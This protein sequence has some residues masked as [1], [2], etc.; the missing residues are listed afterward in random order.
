MKTNIEARVDAIN[1]MRKYINKTVPQLVEILEAGFTRKNDGSLFKKDMERL[2][3]VYHNEPK[4]MRAW[5]DTGDYSI[6]M[7]FD[8]N[9]MNQ[10]GGSGCFYIKE[11]VYLWNIQED[12]AYT[13]TPLE[14][15]TVKQYVKAQELIRSNE[16]KIEELQTVN[17]RLKN[18]LDMPR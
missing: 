5:L 8:I 3:K 6:C 15:I 9:Y 17:R 2:Q 14:K 18:K 12:K 1:T 7:R 10:E 16:E 13:Y 4:N 11:F